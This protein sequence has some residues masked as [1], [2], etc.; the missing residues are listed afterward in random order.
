MLNTPFKALSPLPLHADKLPLDPSHTARNSS[1]LPTLPPLGLRRYACCQPARGCT[2][3]P[4]RGCTA[5]RPQPAWGC[6]R[7]RW[8]RPAWGC[9]RSRCRPRLW[10]CRQGR[11]GSTAGMWAST[12]G[13]WASTAARRASTAG[14]SAST[15][16]S[17]GSML[18]RHTPAGQGGLGTGM[19]KGDWGQG[20]LDRDS[21][22]ALCGR[23]PCTRHA[24][25]PHMRD[26]VRASWHELRHP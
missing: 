25:Q 16:G 10:G 26:L 5:R 4:A 2:P 12:A 23:G 13:R 15:W 11:W 20:W 1:V 14:T 19:A 22:V 7:S 17:S 21:K 8:R 9:S 24:G 6:S 3:A 18:R